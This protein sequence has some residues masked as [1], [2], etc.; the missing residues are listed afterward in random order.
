MGELK[1]V[2]ILWLM[3]F[4]MIALFESIDS[5][6]L[7]KC[8]YAC[9]SGIVH[10]G[11]MISF[12][13]KPNIG[14]GILELSYNGYVTKLYPN[15]SGFYKFNSPDAVNYYTVTISSQEHPLFKLSFFYLGG[16]IYMPYTI[17]GLS[18]FLTM[19]LIPSTIQNG[20]K[21]KFYIGGID[22]SPRSSYTENCKT[23]EDGIN[24]INRRSNFER[25]CISLQE[26]KLVVQGS[27]DFYPRLTD[28]LWECILNSA[29]DSGIQICYYGPGQLDGCVAFGCAN[30]S[31]KIA[32]QIAPKI[33]RLCIYDPKDALLLASGAISAEHN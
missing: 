10:K 26:L 2:I 1:R 7:A 19:K 24:L 18:F 30:T 22:N 33:M 3:S 25:D 14:N 16:I 20:R 5:W 23:I 9:P 12:E 29:E 15:N 8:Y 17:L 11:N 4:I 27:N 28:E 32:N 21:L 13:A 6:V 31:I